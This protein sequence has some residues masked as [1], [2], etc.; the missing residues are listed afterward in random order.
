MLLECMFFIRG[1]I[2]SL[3]I[4]V[5]HWKDCINMWMSSNSL[6][7]LGLVQF[8]VTPWT[9][10]FQAPLS[11]EFSRQEYRSGCHFLL[12]G[13][14][15]TQIPNWTVSKFPALA[16]R[17]SLYHLG[18]PMHYERAENWQILKS[19]NF[20]FFLNRGLLWWL[21]GKESTHA[22]NTRSIPG[23]GRSTG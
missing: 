17:L 12:Q 23:S 1:G 8:S 16:E 4:K 14:F 10:A 19:S 7:L 9:V 20:F 5:R 18:G 11:M 3:Y 15:P 13:I 2:I 22:G 6:C 21:S